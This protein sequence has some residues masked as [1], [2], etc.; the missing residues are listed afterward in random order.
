MQEK[1]LKSRDKRNNELNP[2]C[3]GLSWLAELHNFAESKAFP[4]LD[5]LSSSSKDLCCSWGSRLIFLSFSSLFQCRML[6]LML[7]CLFYP[8]SPS[9]DMIKGIERRR[10]FKDSKPHAHIYLDDVSVTWLRSSPALSVCLAGWL[11]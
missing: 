8:F 10:I 3:L 6:L 5:R 1:S 2:G 11:T 4:V 9:T 7:R